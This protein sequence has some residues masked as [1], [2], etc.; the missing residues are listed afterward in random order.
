M[1]VPSDASLIRAD[2][3][4]A[5]IDNRDPEQALARDSNGAANVARDAVNVDIDRAGKV[6]RRAG[7][8]KIVGAQGA[9]SLWASPEFPFGLYVDNGVLRG[10]RERGETFDIR[11]GMGAGPVS[12]AVAAGRVYWSNA[13]QNGVVSPD[14]LPGDWAVPT[15]GYAH[16]SALATAGGLF[17]GVYQ[18]AVTFLTPTGEESGAGPAAR[19]LVGT[20]G[21]VQIDVPQP[22]DP[23]WRVRIYATDANGDVFYNAFTLPAGVAS[24]LLGAHVN[25][26]QLATQFLEPMLPGHIVRRFGGR[27]LVARN[28]TVTWSEPLRYGLTNVARNA[29]ALP[30]TITMMEPLGDGTDAAGVLVASGDK[31]YWLPGADPAKFNAQIVRAHGVVPGTA[32]RLPGEVFALQTSADVAYWIDASGTG[33]VG[34]AGGEVTTLQAAQAIAPSAVSG[35]SL[36]RDANG[37]RQIVTAL[38]GS[39]ERGLAIGDKVGCAV[40][41]HD[42]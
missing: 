7:Y 26:R 3:W 41:R 5:G 22:P 12:Y 16:V 10:V 31:T 39:Q 24:A 20:G 17:A 2:S 14:G 36:Y 37:L 30:E 9:A 19:V 6:A 21:G 38:R 1:P 15:P 11:G 4:A 29:V 34:L 25:G 18:V 28:N 23:T 27:L 13:A 42:A 8:T 35:A 33:C 40:Y 32:L